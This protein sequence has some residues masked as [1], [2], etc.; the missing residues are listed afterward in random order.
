MRR[1]R[2]TTPYFTAARFPG[3]CPET[4]KAIRKGDR[5]AYFPASRQAYAEDSKAAEQVRGLDF[6]RS[7]AMPDA[8]Y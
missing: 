4:G 2:N 1:S 8:D 7:F 3:T 6:A 5:I